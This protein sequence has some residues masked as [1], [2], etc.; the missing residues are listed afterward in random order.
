MKLLIIFMLL[1]SSCSTTRRLTTHT[2]Q[3]ATD[4]TISDTRTEE[5]R[6]QEGAAST[7]TNTVTEENGEQVTIRREYDTTQPTDTATGRPPLMSET[8][9]HK[10]A[11][12]KTEQQQAG[13]SYLQEQVTNLA[14]D[15]TRHDTTTQADN[16]V[17]ETHKR[18]PT[19]WLWLSIAGA[20][21]VV[22]KTKGLW[23]GKS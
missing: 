10:T 16:Q 1:L 23:M 2:Q 18:R 17:E 21:V 6:H 15:N 13:N 9:T 7:A 19:W 8:I 3:T 5:S 14:T 12:K 4:K 22:Y 11:A 20:I